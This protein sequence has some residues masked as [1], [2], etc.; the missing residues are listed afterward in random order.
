MKDMEYRNYYGKIIN[1][2]FCVLL[3]LIL[4]LSCQNSKNK[5][6]LIK[7]ISTDLLIQQ[8]SKKETKYEKLDT[9]LKV[10]ESFIV[11]D[12]KCFWEFNFITNDGVT[13]GEG[14]VHLKYSNTNKILLSHSDFYDLELFNSLDKINFDFNGAFKDVNF[15][16][17]KD[18]VVYSWQNSGSG[19]AFYN[20]YL[21]DKLSKTFIVSTELSGGEFELNKTNKTVSTYWKMGVGWN[22][23][24]VHH[25]D[26]R[27][28]IKFTEITTR[29]IIAEDTSDL[30]KT[31]Y[32]KIVN[33]K[34]IKTEVD[35]ANFE[36]Y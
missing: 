12:M 26:K 36:G 20:V 18:F 16:G 30:L 24:Q 14:A 13:G 11:N 19:G 17:L 33:G 3:I 9:L 29:E 25:F 22:S 10:S 32:K 4:L 15:D 23:S 27:G 5:S 2:Y 35:T 31:T 6:V 28:K 21:F 1:K 34:I 7:N 8:V